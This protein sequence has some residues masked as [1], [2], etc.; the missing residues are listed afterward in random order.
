MSRAN[1]FLNASQSWYRAF[2]SYQRMWLA[3]NE[4]I[5]RRT[6]QM[7][8]GTMTVAEATRMVTEKP[9]AF[10]RAAQQAGQAAVAGKSG[11]AIAAAAIKPVRRRAQNNVTRLR[12]K[13]P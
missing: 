4:V 1:P 9:A 11:A 2:L 12:R 6:L 5:L 3:A 10:A 13:A 7:A 8:T